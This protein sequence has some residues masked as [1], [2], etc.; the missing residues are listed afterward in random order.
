MH[1]AQIKHN[2]SRHR[3]LRVP[4]RRRLIR[5]AVAVVLS[6]RE[7]G[8]SVLLM[9][10]AQRDGDPWSG[11]MAFPGGRLSRPDLGGGAAA[12]RETQEETGLQLVQADRIGRLHDRVTRAHRQPLPM[13]VS[14]FVY[15]FPR[16][17]GGWRLNHEVDRIVWVPLDY[18]VERGNR[19]RMQ[20]QLGP[21]ALPLP[22]YDYQDHRIWG[23][24]L[25]M[26]DE[27]MR[28]ASRSR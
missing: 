13:V 5:A 17:A 20:W 23:L 18:L 8:L 24:T 3:A 10:R 6:E 27:L 14:P 26:L 25:L 15:A 1:F 28:I 11:D 22:C 16:D 4:G 9:R 7:A 2:L 21:L 19:A 12:C